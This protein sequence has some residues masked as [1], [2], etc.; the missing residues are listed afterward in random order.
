MR[1]L[2]AEKPKAHSK[3][4]SKV[5]RV[6]LQNPVPTTLLSF[7]QEN[8]NMGALDLFNSFRKD[9]TPAKNQIVS[10]LLTWFPEF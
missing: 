4:G 3:S 2:N 6:S 5:R 9:P 10:L 7:P 1:I 8:Q